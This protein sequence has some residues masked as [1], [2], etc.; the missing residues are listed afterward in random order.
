[1]DFYAFLDDD[2]DTMQ[3]H[4]KLIILTNIAIYCFIPYSICCTC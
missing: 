2:N 4:Y 1:M 3:I